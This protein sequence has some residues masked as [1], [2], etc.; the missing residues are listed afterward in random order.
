MFFFCQWRFWCRSHSELIVGNLSSRFV[1]PSDS[2]G[3]HC[4]GDAIKMGEVQHPSVSSGS[5]CIPQ[6]GKLD[7]PDAKIKFFAAEAPEEFVVLSLTHSETV[8]PT[9]LRYRREWC[10]GNTCDL[11]Y[12]IS[13]RGVSSTT[14]QMSCA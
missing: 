12:A 2:D 7:D 8:L 13:P 5:R 9:R 1:A 3:E 10:M 11:G 4:I 6:A 14:F